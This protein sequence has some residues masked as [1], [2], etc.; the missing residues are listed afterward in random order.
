MF[1]KYYSNEWI[2]SELRLDQERCHHISPENGTLRKQKNIQLFWSTYTYLLIN[3]TKNAINSKEKRRRN[4]VKLKKDVVTV[5]R[6]RLPKQPKWPNR[7]TE[8]LT[9]E[10]QAQT[11]QLSS[12][13]TAEPYS[14]QSINR[15][16]KRKCYLSKCFGFST[17]GSKASVVCLKYSI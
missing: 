15:K 17:E 9:V 2:T 3:R 6:V 16:I 10:S 12:I 4:C 8:T 5:F 13:C 14:S 1:F 7:K 11:V